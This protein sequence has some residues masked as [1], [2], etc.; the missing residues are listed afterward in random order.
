M[1]ETVAIVHPHTQVNLNNRVNNNKGCAVSSPY[2]TYKSNNISIMGGFV[3]RQNNLV[4][5]RIRDG[6]FL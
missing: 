1:A 2:K 6:D 3:T 4:T 5:N